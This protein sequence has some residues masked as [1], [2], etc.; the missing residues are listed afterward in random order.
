M[1]CTHKVSILILIGP[2]KQCQKKWKQ[3][4]KN[5][6]KITPKAHAYLQTMT[7]TSAKFQKVWYKTVRGV[8]STSYPHHRVATEKI[9][10]KKCKKLKKG[11]GRITPKPHAHLWFSSIP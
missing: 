5:D 9:K 11:N 2:E 7:R 6:G 4:I 3:L 8:A 10:L 1:S